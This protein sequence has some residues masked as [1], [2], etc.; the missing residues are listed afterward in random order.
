ML[1]FR[2][3]FAMQLLAILVCLFLRVYRSVVKVCPVR[4][5]PARLLLRR[6]TAR[7]SSYTSSV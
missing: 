6:C 3:F 4:S 5:A 2:N 7:L 1:A